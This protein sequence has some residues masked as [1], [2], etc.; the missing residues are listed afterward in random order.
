ME[1]ALAVGALL[2][3]LAGCEL[4]TNGIEWFGAK[5]RLSTGVCGSV[6]AAVGTALPE[7]IVPIVAI[8]IIGGEQATEV[9]I[10]GILGAPFML[11]TLAFTVTA[12]GVLVYTQRGRRASLDMNVDAHVL[13][14]DLSYFLVAYLIA[15][16]A[17]FVPSAPVKWGIGLGLL[18]LY[19]HYVWLH[20]RTGTCIADE[21]EMAPLRI[22]PSALVPRLRWVTLQVVLGLGCIFVGAHVFVEHLTE[23]AHMFAVP[24]LVL[25]ILITPVATELPEKFNSVLWVRDGKD[26][27]AMGNITGA[28][29][30]QSTIP[31]TV[32]MIFTPWD[33][34]GQHAALASAVIALLS[35]TLVYVYMR[36][37]GK[38]SPWALLVGLPLYAAFL[39]VAFGNGATAH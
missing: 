15:V 28:M 7:T 34:Q 22:Q 31:V 25:S 6:L 26:T 12:I 27:L 10:G 39:A 23:V 32:G 1:I 35:G 5:L 24:A 8:L 21:C 36:T 18:L 29:V 16:A 17:S 33:F 38:L 20:F 9:G 19:A 13:S 37:Q 2:V 30:F 4:F 3:I 11:A 14:H